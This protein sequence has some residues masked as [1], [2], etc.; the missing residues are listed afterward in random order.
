MGDKL[1]VV[2]ESARV[3]EAGASWTGKGEVMD[4]A[5]SCRGPITP[6]VPRPSMLPK[7]HATCDIEFRPAP[8]PTVSMDGFQAASYMCLLDSNTIADVF[9]SRRRHTISSRYQQPPFQW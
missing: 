4:I 1:A 3:Q 9:R 7:S 8:F 5:C 6:G 2:V